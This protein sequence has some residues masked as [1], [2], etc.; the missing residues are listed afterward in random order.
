[1]PLL[2]TGTPLPAITQ[3]SL[4]PIGLPPLWLSK[5]APIH[6]WAPTLIHLHK[7]GQSSSF[8]ARGV[9]FSL[10]IS[11]FPKV[12]LSQG[13]QML[14][15]SPQ[16]SPPQPPP[17][18]DSSLLPPDAPSA[19]QKL[20]AQ[21]APP[22]HSAGCWDSSSSGAPGRTAS[23][24][25]W[26]LSPLAPILRKARSSSKPLIPKS[27][28]EQTVMTAG[29]RNPSPPLSSL[30]LPPEVQEKLFAADADRS[31]AQLGRDCFGSFTP[32]WGRASGI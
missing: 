15:L 28:K 19:E 1:M 16:P 6:R 17:P 5:L 26:Q 30:A 22:S 32:C 14:P 21:Q 23:L 2:G 29:R 25:W 12:F 27:K 3:E 31:C 4:D 20:V 7:S 9:A 8:R 13:C 10:N 18:M 24:C 11:A